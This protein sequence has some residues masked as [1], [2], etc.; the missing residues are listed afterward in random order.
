[1]LEAVRQE[2]AELRRRL[3]RA[4]QFSAAGPAA[5]EAA[6]TLA[7]VTEAVEQAEATYAAPVAAV[8]QPPT[9]TAAARRPIRLGDTVK[10]KNLNAIGVV[11]A[12]TAT[13]AE[14]QVGRMRIR[15]RLDEI[16][17]RG[18]PDP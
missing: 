8:V 5:A 18:S 17:L 2:V 4:A 3:A 1:E 6:E 15:A 14:V 11:T 13:E 9:R 7:E 12:L 16:E 10:L